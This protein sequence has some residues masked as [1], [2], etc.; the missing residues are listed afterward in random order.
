MN[1]IYKMLSPLHLV[2]I[3]TADVD[4]EIFT[5][6]GDSL[7]E[8][9]LVRIIIGYEKKSRITHYHALCKWYS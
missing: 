4:I 1:T 8:S 5:S 6:L 3:L 7:V 9:F 2:T